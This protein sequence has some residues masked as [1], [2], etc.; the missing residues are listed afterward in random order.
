MTICCASELQQ[1]NA[2]DK[3]EM[4]NATE[5]D[6]KIALKFNKVEQS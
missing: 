1:F 2:G 6:K 4:I 5:A 3:L